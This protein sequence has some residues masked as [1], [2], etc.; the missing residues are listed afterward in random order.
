MADLDLLVI[1]L[2][3]PPETFLRR[4]LYGLAD[5]G[6][7]ITLAATGRLERTLP[8][9]PNLHRLPLTSWNRQP[10]V[11]LSSLLSVTL[12]ALWRAPRATA[13]L[14]AR[15][16]RPRWNEIRGWHQ[17]AP[18]V[19]RGWDAVYFPWN[20]SAIDYSPVFEPPAG[21]DLPMVV[22]CRGAQVNTAPHN[23]AR[24][25][26]R[27]GLRATF[28]RATAVH[29]VSRAILEE[30][31]RYDLDPAKAWI[32]HPAVDT[33]R[34]RPAETAPPDA[35]F[36]IVTTGNMIWRKG[37]EYALMTLRELLNRGVPARFDMIGDGP[38]RQRVLNTISDLELTDRVR[39][40]GKLSSTEVRNRLR[41]SHAFLLSSLSEGVSNAVLEAM[42]CGLPVVTTDCGG[43]T[44]AVTDGEDGLVVPVRE[45]AAAAAALAE[46]AR[47][48]PLRE[49][50]GDAARQTVKRRFALPRQIARYAEMFRSLGP[51]R[52][53]PAADHRT[54]D[55]TSI[56][57]TSR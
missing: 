22:S 41:S 47:S 15:H 16:T 20:T 13:R 25:S 10:A 50:L 49:R 55:H 57:S 32:I 51:A 42:A 1:G 14:L 38:E 36:Q 21:L 53:R 52:S 40:L 37:F 30:A 18:F 9:H 5:S 48:R 12:G 54:H 26:I 23:P 29:C 4:L 34:F 35:E 46:L 7:A 19:G 43:M 17:L 39:L 24:A 8:A 27:D 28:E 3:W 56:A 45:P 2:A 11:R 33:E 44:E 31:R 6:I